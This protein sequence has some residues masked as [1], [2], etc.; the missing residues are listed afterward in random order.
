MQ[1]EERTKLAIMIAL[2]SIA[3]LLTII[4]HIILENGPV[5]T[6]FFYLP[7]TL[8]A[9]WYRKWGFAIA[10]YLGSTLIITDLYTGD[11]RM[12]A[13]DLMRTAFFLIVV[14]VVVHLSER[15]LFSQEKLESINASLESEVARQTA[16]LKQANIDLTDELKRRKEAEAHLAEET[17]RLVV[18]LSSIGDGV[19]VTDTAG[20]VVMMNAIAEHLTGRSAQA[21]EGKDVSLLFPKVDADG[22]LQTPTT[23]CLVDGSVHDLYG[24]ALLRTDDDR[25]PISGT[26]AP[27]KMGDEIIGAVTVLRDESEKEK[28]RKQISRAN[29]VRTIELMAGGVAHDLNNILTVLS[30]N[31]E[32]VRMRVGTDEMANKRLDEG[33]KAIERA[34]ELIQQMMALAKADKLEKKLVSLGPVVRDAVEFN[35][36]D[37]NVRGTVDIPDDLW[38][39]LADEV[40]IRGVISNMVINA[41]QEMASGG[42]LS[43]KVRNEKVVSDNGLSLT[44]GRYVRISIKDHGGGIAEKDLER[45][46]EPYYTT[47]R[48]GKGLGLAISHS[49]VQAHNGHIAVES[50]VGQGTTFHI[51]LPAENGT[52]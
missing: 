2:L 35:L 4:F 43:A 26:V 17:E 5:F 47:K 8:G 42:E 34:R 20:R 27:I 44:P 39:V 40:Q 23:D 16:E 6:Q 13:D 48:K 22:R 21:S 32:L 24:L 11:I 14:T 25:V 50:K 49:T 1:L 33:D 10:A 28:V 31:V 9:I 41:R 52:S 12:M 15:L 37:S 38:D 46:F 36:K 7:L 19:I 29:R 45:I 18:T 30:N 51:Y 3:T